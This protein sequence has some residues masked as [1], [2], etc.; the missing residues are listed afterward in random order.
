MTIEKLYEIFLQHPTVTT[1]SREC[2][3][4]SLFFALKGD[5]FNG[6][7]F[8]LS[9]LQKGCYRAVVDEAQYAI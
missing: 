9:A 5:N 4:G 7:T 3:D 2:P 1:D 8:A 6:N